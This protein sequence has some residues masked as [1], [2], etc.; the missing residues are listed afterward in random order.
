MRWSRLSAVEGISDLSVVLHPPGCLQL[1]LILDAAEFKVDA[2]YTLLE[3]VPAPVLSVDHLMIDEREP[4][5]FRMTV[6]GELP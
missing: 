5:S 1:S 2:S 6:T 4:D 3:V